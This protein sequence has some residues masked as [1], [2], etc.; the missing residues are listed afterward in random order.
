MSHLPL[1]SSGD[2]KISDQGGRARTAS[3]ATLTDSTSIYG[4]YTPSLTHDSTLSELVVVPSAPEPTVL[5][6]EI[7]QAADDISQLVLFQTN[8]RLNFGTAAVVALERATRRPAA[9]MRDAEM[10]TRLQTRLE[11]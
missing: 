11:D 2:G 8:P 9:D 4:I 5:L 7:Q 10:Q 6:R 3:T 1:F